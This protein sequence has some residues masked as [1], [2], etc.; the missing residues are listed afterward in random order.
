MF[1]DDWTKKTPTDYHFNEMIKSDDRATT[2]EIIA[3]L[4]GYSVG[5]GMLSKEDSIIQGLVGIKMKE[6]DPLTIGY[7]TR[8]AP[9]FLAAQCCEHINRALVVISLST[10]LR[11]EYTL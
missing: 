8:K 1:P 7:I 10:V 6:E 3:A 9:P 11:Q 2:M 5:S 4:G